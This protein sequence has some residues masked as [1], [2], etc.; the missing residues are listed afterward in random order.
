MLSREQ[1]EKIVAEATAAVRPKKEAANGAGGKSWKDG[2]ITARELQTK[3][4]E[5]V[6]II[7]PELIPEGVTVLA[8]KPKIGK[9]WFALDVCVAVAGGRFV[10]GEVKPVQGDALYLALED[11]ERRLKKR[12]EKIFGQGPWPERLEM[13]TKWRK[14]DQGGLD[15]IEAWCRLHP[16]RRL[17]WIDTLVKVRPKAG[18]NDQ[19][20]I[21]DYQAI[22][23]L[24][25]LAGKY[26]L[27]IVLNH[28][29]R[30][31]SS[32]DDAFDDVSGTLGLTGAA[33]T[34]IVMK[35]HAGM[36]KVFVRG[37]DIEEAEF[38]AEFNRNTSRWR[39]VGDAAEV[40]RSKERQA[41]LAALKAAT[42]PMSIPDIMAATERVDRNATKHLL[43]KMRKDGEV[44]SEKGRYSLAPS[45][46]S[47]GGN[48]GNRDDFFA[49]DTLQPI[50]HAGSISP[51]A[52]LPA[53]V[54]GRLPVT[55]AVTAQK[56][57]KCLNNSEN[58]NSGYRVTAVT[59]ISRGTNDGR[60]I[61][62]PSDHSVDIPTALR[63][64]QHCG[65]PG[66]ERRDLNGRAVY[67]HAA[68]EHAWADQQ[69]GGRQ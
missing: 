30:K 28:H 32:E 39:L 45:D 61:T 69:D 56:Q 8:G 7:L 35:R 47:N 3:Q 67:L 4:F 64:C 11:S 13:H 31:M 20:Y 38:A 23:G 22:E 16:H 55:G 63:R 68:C 66:A 60:N 53:A 54:T 24:Q 36:T 34:I 21:A 52:R 29:L 59:G 40:F 27:G 43:Y 51:E 42:E 65:K 10:L 1:I 15:D 48:R 57:P 14:L 50:D 58:F 6:R 49:P 12:M 37:R 26:Q 41:V 62:P 5:P 33:D 2:L 46:P 9:S 44:V 25:Q 17:I 18:R 19:A